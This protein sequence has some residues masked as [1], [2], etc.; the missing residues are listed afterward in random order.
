MPLQL[1]SRGRRWLR[2]SRTP[3]RDRELEDRT[4][5]SLQCGVMA[6]PGAMNERFKCQTF[7]KFTEKL[8]SCF[9]LDCCSTF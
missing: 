3:R 7:K 6:P 8:L 2:S 1:V 9:P 4:T 5:L